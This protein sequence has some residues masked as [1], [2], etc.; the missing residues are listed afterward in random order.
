MTK[1]SP[2][3][4]VAIPT[5]NREEVLLDTIQDVLK[6]QSFKNLELLVVDQTVEHQPSTEKALRAIKDPRFRY[7]RADPPSLTAARNF[8]IKKARA[9]YLIFLDDDVKLDK[10]LVGTFLKTFRDMPELS[11]IAGRVMQ[12]GF[13]SLPMLKFDEYGVSHGGYTGS[14][15]GFTNAFPG[16][17]LG[18]VIKDALKAGGFDTRY[19]GNAFREEND[20]SMRMSKLGMK[21]YY[22]P[23]AKLTHLAAPYGGLRVKTHIYDNRGF[24]VNELFFTLRAVKVKNLPRSLVRKYREYCRSVRGKHSFKRSV[25]FISGIVS[26]L[27]RMAFGRHVTT[28]ERA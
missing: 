2:A 24:Y 27:C 18:I 7:F 15:A 25:L 19:R 17:N 20:L 4:T 3:I 26:A 22:Q 21:I 13:K 28:R 5:Y 6:G 10:D 8:A 23:E 11:A 14:T 9:P 12:K 16:G 1:Q